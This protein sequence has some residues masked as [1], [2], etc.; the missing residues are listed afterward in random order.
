VRRNKYKKNSVLNYSKTIGLL[1]L[2]FVFFLSTSVFKE[3]K[4]QQNLDGRI[5]ELKSE[6]QNIKKNNISLTQMVGYLESDE[7]F[8]MEARR[9]LGYKKEGEKVVVVNNFQQEVAKKEKVSQ[10]NWEKWF[11]YFFD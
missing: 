3:Y 4:K 8:E 2:L 11:M 10:E 6:M 5:Q 7:Y 9:N 1:V